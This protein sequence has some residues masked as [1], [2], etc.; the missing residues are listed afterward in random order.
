MFI[1][2]RSDWKTRYFYIRYSSII[3]GPLKKKK[4]KNPIISADNA[5]GVGRAY[6]YVA[7]RVIIFINIAG[8]RLSKEKKK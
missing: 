2:V 1:P 8:T 7:A 5:P 4:G 6:A 3:I